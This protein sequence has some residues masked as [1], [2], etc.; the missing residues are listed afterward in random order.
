MSSHAK[1]VLSASELR[2]ALAKL[3]VYMQQTGARYCISGGA[4]A[5]LIRTKNGMK[6]RLTAD[7]DLV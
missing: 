5:L 1:P 6:A 2:E 4:A 3:A 7:I